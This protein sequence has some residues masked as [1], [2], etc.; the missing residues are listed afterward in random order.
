MEF[1]GGPLIALGL[2]TRLLA[3][4]FSGEMAVAFWMS[5]AQRGQGF[6]PIQNEGELAVLYCFLF[7]FIAA[8]GAGRWSV[9]GSRV[10]RPL[11]PME[12][13]ERDASSIN[14]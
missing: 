6:W 14:P 9:T 4:L 13:A 2:F 5:H 11:T 12:K 3:F 1:F 8:Q 7:L 10:S